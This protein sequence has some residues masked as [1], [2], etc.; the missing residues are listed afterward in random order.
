M[1]GKHLAMTRQSE[2]H[3]RQ[4]TSKRTIWRTPL[5][6]VQRK[7]GFE[8]ERA[9]EIAKELIGKGKAR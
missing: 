5:K 6:Q 8:P 2:T 1:I 7:F 9:T 4:S 3:R